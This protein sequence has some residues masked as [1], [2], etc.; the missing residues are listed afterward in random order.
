MDQRHTSEVAQ[1]DRRTHFPQQY[2]VVFHPIRFEYLRNRNNTKIR[3]QRKNL[4]RFGAQPKNVLACP[5]RHAHSTKNLILA[6][7]KQF[8]LWVLVNYRG[9]DLKLIIFC[10][11]KRWK[12]VLEGF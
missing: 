3:M 8:V 2:K 10:W 11:L 1:S 6:P 9:A 7:T 12:R 4:E 5:S